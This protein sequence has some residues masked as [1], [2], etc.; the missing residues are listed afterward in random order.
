MSL[1]GKSIQSALLTEQSSAIS[2]LDYHQARVLILIDIFTQ[3]R[4]RPMRSLTKLAKLDFLLRYPNFMERFLPG[5]SE[6][7]TSDTRPSDAEYLA[8]ESRVIRYK[9][10][11]WDDRYYPILGALVG[12]GLLTLASTPAGLEMHP[13][14]YGRR[15]ATLLKEDPSWQ[16]TTARAVLLRKHLNHSGNRLKQLIYSQLPDELDRPWGSEI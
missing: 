12:R 1:D 7:W 2:E 6:C 5:R 14:Q 8:V 15:I 11:P 13:T 3:G 9:Y 10:G 4:R 16:T